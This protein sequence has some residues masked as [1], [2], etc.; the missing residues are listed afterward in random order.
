MTS[1]QYEELCRFFVADQLRIPVESILSLE[2][3]S[4][5]RGGIGR[6]SHQIDLIWLTGNKMARY[7]NIANAKWRSGGKK[8]G[9]ADVLLLGKVRELVGAHKA[10]MITSGS[11]S[12][13]AKAAAGDDGIGLITVRPAFDP[14]RLTDDRRVIIHQIREIARIS[15]QVYTYQIE[16]QGPENVLSGYRCPHFSCEHGRRLAIAAALTAGETRGLNP[17]GR[18]SLSVTGRGGSDSVAGKERPK[19]KVGPW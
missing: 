16:D 3:P 14:A 5:G 8:V 7:L 18:W 1:Q 19:R 15:K 10:F 6:F 12:E 4:A 13:Q 2:V 17:V 11:Y 9:Q